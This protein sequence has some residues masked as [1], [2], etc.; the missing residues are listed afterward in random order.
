MPINELK[1]DYIPRVRKLR[2]PAK[3]QVLSRLFEGQWMTAFKG[4]GMEFAGFRRYQY[5]DDASL[6]DWKASL[7]SKEVLIREFEKYQTV[8]IYFLID[9][10]NSMLFSSTGKLKCEYAAEL[11]LTLIHAMVGSGDYVGLG[12]FT[13]KLIAKHKPRTGV[14]SYY[15][16]VRDLSDPKLYG[17]GFDIKKAIKQS[18]AFLNEK[19]LFIIVSDFISLGEGWQYHLRYLSHNY[20]LIG[21]MVRDPRDKQLPKTAGDYVLQNPYTNEKLVVD[22]A[23]FAKHYKKDVETQEESLRSFFKKSRAGF[24]ELTTDQDFYNPILKFFNKRV[25]MMRM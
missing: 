17:G 4:R 11:V 3:R 15:E 10:S 18:I 23:K 7:K 21:I 2:V 16:L 12:M 9:V 13:D 5:G 25:S 8:N 6:I 19:C 14:N 24:L 1:L 20:D 22:T